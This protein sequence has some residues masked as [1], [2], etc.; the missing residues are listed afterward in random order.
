MTPKEKIAYN[1]AYYAAR[2]ERFRA[3]ALSRY[4]AYGKHQIDRAARAEYH[5]AW[6]TTNPDKAQGSPE[7]RKSRYQKDAIRYKTDPVYRAKIQA[8]NRKISPRRIMTKRILG[9]KN[10]Y[11]LTLAEYEAMIISQQGKCLICLLD[12]GTGR[13]KRRFLHVDHDHETGRVRGMLCQKC[14]RG[15]GL[16]NDDVDRLKRAIEYL[17]RSGK[18]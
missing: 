5:K 12:K 11:G 1:K 13:D 2:K 18:D 4:H 6:R 16:Y 9:L 10:K 14:N 7:K 8:K 17:G 15:L 3:E